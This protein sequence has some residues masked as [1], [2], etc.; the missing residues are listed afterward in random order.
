MTHWGRMRTR[1]SAAARRPVAIVTMGCPSSIGPELSL[2]LLLGPRARRPLVLGDRGALTSAAKARGL[3]KTELASVL[4]LRGLDAHGVPTSGFLQVGDALASSDRAPGKPSKAGG[5][6]QLAYVEEGYRLAKFSGR[7]LVT[8]AVS[9]EAVATCGLQ[10]AR[11]FRG[12]TEWLEALDGAPFSVMCFASPRLVTALVTTHVPLANVSRILSPALVTRTTVALTQLVERLGKR[13]PRI[14]VCSFNPH[15]GE[16]G[17]LGKEERTAIA[18]GVRRAGAL[19][20]KRSRKAAQRQKGDGAMVELVGPIG[21]ETAYRLAV[22]GDFD[23]VVGI[24]HDQVTIPMKLLDFGSAVNVTAGLSIVRTSVDHGTAYDIAGKGIAR[25][26]GLLAAVRLAERLS[27]GDP[28]EGAGRQGAG[29]AA[30]G[31]A[32]SSRRTHRRA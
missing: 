12:H 31:G 21:A 26:D 6:A 18:P 11:S 20:A 10:R 16:G 25:A 24:Y 8:N 14:A 2:Q 30:A 4:E 15:A 27:V 9:K 29:R 19:L 23:G 1:D 13:A 3:S 32:A 5:R 22:R 7:P 17:L 28:P